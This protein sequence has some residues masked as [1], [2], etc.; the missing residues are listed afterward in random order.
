[1]VKNQDRGLNAQVSSDPMMN[2]SNLRVLR[3]A[4]A[5][6]SSDDE[7]SEEERT[8]EDEGMN[9]EDDED[10]QE[11]LSTSFHYTSLLLR[12]CSISHRA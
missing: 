11:S 9:E 10:M 12:H 8:Y 5:Q 2:Q 3:T 7:M 4:K 6:K 1:M